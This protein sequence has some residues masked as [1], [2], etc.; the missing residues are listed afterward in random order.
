VTLLEAIQG[1]VSIGYTAAELAAQTVLEICAQWSLEPC[2]A[3]EVLFVMAKRKLPCGHP[4]HI[5]ELKHPACRHCMA[6][7]LL[8]EIGQV[9]EVYP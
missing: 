6:I 2:V 5:R 4:E 7:F 1:R 8:E 3:D 9:I